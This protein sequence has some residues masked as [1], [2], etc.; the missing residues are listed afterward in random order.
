LA[1]AR[2]P[3]LRRR[4]AEHLAH[5]SGPGGVVEPG[6]LGE[7]PRGVLTDRHAQR[8]GRRLD[9][10]GDP[11]AP[12]SISGLHAAALMTAAPWALAA[13]WAF[14]GIPRKVTSLRLSG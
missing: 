3:V 12:G 8:A 7:H 1:A 2:G 11:A 14:A 5:P 9:R 13:A 6:A 4:E 10:A